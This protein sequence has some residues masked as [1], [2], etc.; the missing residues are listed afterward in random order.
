VV[1]TTIRSSRDRLLRGAPAPRVL[2]EGNRTVVW[3][4]G[5]YD[6][7]DLTALAAGLADAIALDDA[8]LVVDLTEV[9]FIDVAA[10]GMLVRAWQY[11]RPRS[12]QLTLRNPPRSAQRVLGRWGLTGLFD[13]APGAALQASH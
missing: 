8:H 4:S 13:T 9:Q 6:V 3:L 12:R 10:V 2:T 5:E 7:A 11:L 1:A